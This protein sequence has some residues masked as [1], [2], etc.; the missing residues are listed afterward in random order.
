MVTG[1]VDGV[2]IVAALVPDGDTLRLQIEVPEDLAGYIAR[3]G[4]VTVDG[5]S[6]TINSVNGTVFGVAI[7]PHTQDATI[8]SQYAQG[9]RVNIEVDIIARYLERL[10]EYTGG[11]RT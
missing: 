7:I 6:L 11:I 2:G 9:S 8:I 3:K 5:V 10:V 4:S 1:H